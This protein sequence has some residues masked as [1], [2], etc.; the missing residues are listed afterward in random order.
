MTDFILSSLNEYPWLIHVWLGATILATALRAAYPVTEE[1]P[2]WI[3]ALLAITD[4]VQL[5]PSGP[6]KLLAKPKDPVS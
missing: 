6:V 2:R 4:L 1:R 5:N 3:V